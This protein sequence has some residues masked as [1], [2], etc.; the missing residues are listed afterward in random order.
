LQ[1]GN[2]WR[3]RR[4]YAPAEWGGYNQKTPQQPDE[5]E[6]RRK[7][8]E[9]SPQGAPPG[10]GKSKWGGYNEITPQRS[11]AATTSAS[12]IGTP[13]VVATP[14]SPSLWRTHLLTCSYP[15]HAVR[16]LLR[17]CNFRACARY[18]PIK[19]LMLVNYVV[20]VEAFQIN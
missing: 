13:Y 6:L 1:K 8:A 10:G 12:V 17:F 16:A 20:D 3:L 19:S 18:S 15:P 9:G 7:T 14:P 4:D 5:R 2:T 11:G